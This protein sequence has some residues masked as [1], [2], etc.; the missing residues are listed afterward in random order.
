VLRVPA[1]ARTNRRTQPPRRRTSPAPS[2]SSAPASPSSRAPPRCMPKASR[3]L[4]CDW[5]YRD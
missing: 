5:I 3:S 4:R 2:S 1:P